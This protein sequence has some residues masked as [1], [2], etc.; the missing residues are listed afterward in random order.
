ML[1]SLNLLQVSVFH[2]RPV[3][4]SA[5][6]TPPLIIAKLADTVR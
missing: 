4:V 2:L 1:R 6:F 5:R 3:L